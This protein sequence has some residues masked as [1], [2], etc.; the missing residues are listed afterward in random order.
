MKADYP[1]LPSTRWFLIEWPA[2][3]SQIPS[4]ESLSKAFTL[5][6]TL[7]VTFASLVGSVM[8]GGHSCGSVGFFK[9]SGAVQVDV[10]R[11]GFYTPA[12]GQCNVVSR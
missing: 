4:A 1:M 6:I 12:G 2:H 9:G 5:E 3:D 11:K 8:V 10:D 7:F